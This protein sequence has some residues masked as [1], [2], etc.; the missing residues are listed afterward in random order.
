MP[1]PPATISQTSTDFV[2]RF[3]SDLAWLLRHLDR[4]AALA[5]LMELADSVARERGG[6]QTMESSRAAMLS[7]T[8]QAESYTELQQIEQAL[9]ALE[10]A[11]FVASGSVPG[12][13][14]GCTEFRDRLAERS[15]HLVEKE[16]DGQGL[17]MPP[18]SY[19][20]ISMGS[21]GRQEQTLI[22][23][24]DYLIVY[25]DGGSDQ[26]DEYF[27]AFS[28]LLVERL[29]EVGF[30][31]CTGDIMPSN[32]TW[33]GSL[34]QWKRRLM[35][36]VR[37][38]YEEYSKNLMDLIVLSDARF[39][40]GD[41]ATGAE[42][43]GM[44]H[45]FEQSYFQ[46][47]W[48]MARQATEMKVGLSMFGHLWTDREGEYRGLFNIKLLGWAPLVM[49]IRILAVNSGLTVTN[50]LQ[51]IAMLEA[52]RRLSRAN[53]AELEEAYHILTRQRILMQIRYLRGDVQNT[54]FLDPN[55]LS[56][57]EQDSL[58][59]A[60]V[61]IKDLQKVISTNFSTM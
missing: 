42:L 6:I 29:S 22:T 47:I 5:L 10:T 17:G 3:R 1:R 41:A 52:D 32:P 24:Q 31:K 11:R 56:S 48:G 25:A 49:N 28:E 55:E 45:D 34:Q 16:L 8:A 51:R 54:Y 53:A 12:L 13:L 7:R 26:D 15:L 23:D 4:P 19:A 60:L 27:R 37:Y 38:E 21:D 58:R 43:I 39:V 9:T 40:A 46:V 20:L 14:R 33:R 50:T 59:R 30:A 61:S 44:I 18:R 57:D 35:A 36:I 2:E